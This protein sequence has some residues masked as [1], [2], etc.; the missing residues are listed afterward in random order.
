VNLRLRMILWIPA[1]A[2]EGI[3]L[4]GDRTLASPG[5]IATMACF[6][7]M[8]GF[9]LAA[10]FTIRQYRRERIRHGSRFAS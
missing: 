3:L 10:M 9:L 5:Q 7:A 6:G 8:L 1:L 4:T 2:Y